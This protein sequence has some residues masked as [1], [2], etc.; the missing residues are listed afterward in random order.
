MASS[1]EKTYGS[2]LA[3]AQKLAT[4]LSGFT[5][6]T[7]ATP[8]CSLANYQTLI[9]DITTNNSEI[10]TFSALFSTDAQDR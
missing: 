2:R 5:D 6:Y 10:A 1:T 7:P 8:E 3:N 4:D 9:T